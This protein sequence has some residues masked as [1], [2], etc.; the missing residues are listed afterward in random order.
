MSMSNPDSAAAKARSNMMR[1]GL[2][3]VAMTSVIAFFVLTGRVD[4]NEPVEL[5]ARVTQ[6]A[7]WAESGPLTLGVAVTLANNTEEP[8]PLS[9]ASQCDIFRWFLTDDDRNLVQSQRNDEPCVDLPMQ[10]NLEAK[11][12]ISGE[13]TLTL[14]PARVKPGR[15]ILFMRYWGHEHREPVTID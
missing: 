9:L 7:T 15:Y 3:A 6:P 2:V 10:G 12:N 8:L 11:H 5:T 14:D 1:L 13:F 4:L